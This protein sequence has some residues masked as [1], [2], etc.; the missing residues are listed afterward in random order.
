MNLLH[1]YYFQAL[2]ETEHYAKSA[3][4]LHTSASNLNY[5]ITAIE[6]EIGASLF[7]KVGR[8]I[9]LTEN[10]RI[11]LAYVVRALSELE[12]GELAVRR[13]NRDSGKRV[14]RIAAFRLHAANRL[15]QNYN[16][17]AE[18]PIEV[19]MDH[20]KTMTIIDQLKTNTV[21]VGFCTYSTN[22]P[23]ICF[24][25]VE[26]QQLA[27]LIPKG[28]PMS[29]KLQTTLSDISQYPVIIPH[30]SDGMHSRILSMFRKLG[31][32]P[33][34]ACE[35][36]SINAA[37]NLCSLGRGISISVDFPILHYFDLDIVP[38]TQLPERFCLYFS[39]ADSISR[40]QSVTN[41]INYFSA[42][43]KSIFPDAVSL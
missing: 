30:G 38:I 6:Q 40:P 43:S 39:Y 10:G 33:K 23:D 4:L 11:Y 8:N 17:Q 3:E 19:Q 34:I 25:P 7:E 31:L 27:A 32:T 5:A 35:A 15:I 26:L 16:L 29:G 18:H 9:R 21:D 13:L 42:L 22:D 14:V 28:H 1:L 36:D 41:L 20:K 24:I 2:A 12:A 37:A